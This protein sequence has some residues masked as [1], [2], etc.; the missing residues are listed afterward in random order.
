M[1][2]G[3]F[4][5]FTS[6]A[7]AQARHQIRMNAAIM[8]AEAR[9][10]AYEEEEGPKFRDDLKNISSNFFLTFDK[11]KRKACEEATRQMESLAKKYTWTASD[12]AFDPNAPLDRLTPADQPRNP[13]RIKC[14]VLEQKRDPDPKVLLPLAEECL[15]AAT[16]VPA[17]SNEVYKQYQGEFYELAGFVA[18][19]AAQAELGSVGFKE[20][21]KNP[22]KAAAT[23][24]QAWKLYFGLKLEG[25]VNGPCLHQCVLAIAY[26]GKSTDA[27]ALINRSN[28]PRLRSGDPAFWFDV[29]RI[30]SVIGGNYAER[31]KKTPDLALSPLFVQ[32]LNTCQTQAL[33]CLRMAVGTGLSNQE[34][35]RIHPDLEWIRK[36]SGDGFARA[37]GLPN[38]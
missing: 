22:A 28:L 2:T 37:I 9:A 15:R 11:E 12:F 36:V 27:L 18:N 5:G 17:I 16:L 34:S 3:L 32:N 1:A 13:F 33:Y 29:A 35:L 24:Q 7:M 20:A 8:E 25:G 30:L 14:M 19:Q 26:G 31:A 4:A 23:A 21:Q 6:Y 10:R 38:S